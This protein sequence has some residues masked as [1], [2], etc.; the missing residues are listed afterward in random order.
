MRHH[1]TQKMAFTI[2]LK[3]FFRCFLKIY[4]IFY[5]K[6]DKIIRF[7]IINSINIRNNQFDR[8]L[9]KELENLPRIIYAKRKCRIFSRLDIKN[10]F[11][12]INFFSF[13]RSANLKKMTFKGNLTKADST[14]A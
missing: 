12:I 5:S 10:S 7:L 3:K 8:K 6:L 1:T 13:D 14:M 9:K 4:N 11:L 2:S